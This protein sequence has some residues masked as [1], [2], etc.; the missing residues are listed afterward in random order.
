M[1]AVITPVM[2]VR[3]EE[4]FLPDAL[5]SLTALGPVLARTCVYDTGSIDHTIDLALHAGAT[6]R[7]G[8][9]DDDF[10]RAKNEAVAMARSD[11]VLSLDADERVVGD[12]T[13]LTAALRAAEAKGLD[14]LVIDVDDVRGEQI[15]TTAPSV[16]MFRSSRAQFRNRIHEVVVRRDGAEPR[17]ARLPR[18]VLRLR[19]VGYGPVDAMARRKARNSGSVISRSRRRARARIRC[20]S[21]KPSSTGAG[22]AAS[23]AIGRRESRTGARP[24]L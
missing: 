17:G 15:L 1:G 5:E 9:W 19:H 21:S 22:R 16:R 3:D 4:T 10:A 23:A 13:L 24:G 18:E 6:V 11:W 7:R 14:S 8:F 20:A 2:I 12:P